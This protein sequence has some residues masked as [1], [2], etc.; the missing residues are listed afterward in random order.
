LFS[1]LGIGVLSK[2][3]QAHNVLLNIVELDPAVYDLATKYFN[4]EPKHNIYIQDG[5]DFINYEPSQYY[6]YVLHDVFTGG[7]VP[8]SLFSFEA[9]E[10]IKRILKKDG[11]LALVGFFLIKYFGIVIWEMLIKKISNLSEF[12]W[13]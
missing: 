9:L 7:S 12:C 3:L 11:V 1:G 2:S 4:L 13:I 10:Q 5:R 8:S 6:D